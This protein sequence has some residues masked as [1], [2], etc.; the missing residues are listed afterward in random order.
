MKKILAALLIVMATVLQA[1]ELRFGAQA[2]LAMPFGDIAQKEF[3]NHRPAFGFGVHGLWNLHP[4]H[5]FVPRVDITYY[6]INTDSSNWIPFKDAV[7]LRDLKIGVDYN[8]VTK[9]DGLY[10]IAGLNYSSLDWAVPMG[11]EL[12]RESKSTLGFALGMG[13][14]MTS[15][16]LAEVRY[17][18]ASYSDVGRKGIDRTAPA[19]N[20]SFMWRY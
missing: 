15:H 1:Q 8:L 13:Y 2:T 4:R 16:F 6:K 5:V 3:L 17:T 10:G 7:S 9:F 20:L 11:D 14:P 19:V 18:H 12:W